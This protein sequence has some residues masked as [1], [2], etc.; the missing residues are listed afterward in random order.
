MLRGNFCPSTATSNNHYSAWP[1]LD[2]HEFPTSSFRMFTRETSVIIQLNVQM[3]FWM[4][5]V[6]QPQKDKSKSSG[7]QKKG[8]KSPSVHLELWERE[9]H[10]WRPHPCPCT[11]VANIHTR[12]SNA[13]THWLHISLEHHAH[14][15]TAFTKRNPICSLGSWRI[16]HPTHTF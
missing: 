14:R 10:C 15:L 13:I 5:G 4:W 2:H 8:R 7:K 1:K 11:P 3:T 12:Y 16:A 9:L 6:H